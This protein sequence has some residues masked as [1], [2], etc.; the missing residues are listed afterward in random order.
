[1]E[2]D[3]TQGVSVEELAAHGKIS[4]N[5]GGDP[6]LLVRDGNAAFAVG[7]ICTHYGAP[8]IEGVV[9]DGTVRCPWHHACFDLTTGAVLRAPALAPLATY[10]VDERGGRLFV[11]RP[12]VLPETVVIVGAGPAA[13]NAADGLRREGFG[14]RIVM[15]SSE[16][17][18]PYDK[19]NLSKDFLAGKAPPE[20]LPLH[21]AEYYLHQKIEL[22][23]GT[24]VKS[25]DT[26][27]KMITLADGETLAW[28]ALVLATGASIRRLGAP[29]AERVLYLRTRRDAEL[30]VAAA[31]GAQ[32]AVVVGSSFIGLEV[33][34]SLREKG[35]AVTVISPTREPLERVLG[36]LVGAHIRALH[37]KK[38][39]VF[40]ADRSVASVD[41]RGVVLNDGVRVDADLIVAG[42]GVV[43]NVDL[44]RAARISVADGILV[45]A[46][47]RT[48]APSVFA[49][50]DVA[51]WPDPRTGGRTRV[52]H[53]VVAGRQGQTVARNILGRREAF[54]AVPFFW[55]AHYDVVLGYVGHAP[56]FDSVK[57]DGS[58]EKNDATITYGQAGRV[59]AVATIGRDVAN[60]EAELAFERRCFRGD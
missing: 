13:V 45:D 1:M 27:A 35:L 58:L 7:A 6:V 2:R 56:R 50:G 53:W 22:R 17:D 3:L 46:Y 42:V 57:I 18:L 31:S 51:S 34:A 32:R 16:P 49:C 38:G 47:L 5:V 11:T 44:A 15:I 33:A 39:V 28:D 12:G 43:P 60:L 8:L 14:G 59:L 48:S 29:G 20:W 21:S 55:S 9:V 37:E 19:P 4:G 41:E 25:I 54:D 40:C 26:S 52:E 24:V 36:P 10:E 23:L 30:L